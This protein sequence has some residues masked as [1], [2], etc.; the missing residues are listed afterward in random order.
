[1]HYSSPLKRVCSFALALLGM[2]GCI[3]TDAAAQRPVGGHW[4][5]G[6]EYGAAR[7]AFG[8][9]GRLAGRGPCNVIVGGTYRIEGDSIRLTGISATR[10]FCSATVEREA[11]FF[12]RLARVRM[13][14]ISG[15]R[16][17]LKDQNGTTILR[18]VRDRG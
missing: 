11:E 13:F 3:A 5:T 1:M 12:R 2:I 16:L 7:L 10:R 8:A 17:E 6:D 4:R 15:P 14:R 9:D 18:L